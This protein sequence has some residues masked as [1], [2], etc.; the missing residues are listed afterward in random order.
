MPIAE[1]ECLDCGWKCDSR[2][3]WAVGAKHARKH[4]HHVRIEITKVFH[5]NDTDAPAALEKP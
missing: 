1:A 2:N 3:A 5:Y 4:S